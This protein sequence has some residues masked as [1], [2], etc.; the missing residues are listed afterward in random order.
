L[1]SPYIEGAPPFRGHRGTLS[2]CV[3]RSEAE[4]KRRIPQCRFPFCRGR[5]PWS[6]PLGGIGLRP[7]KATAKSPSEPIRL[8]LFVK[9]EFCTPVILRVAKRKRRI[10]QC[11]FPLWRGRVVV[12]PLGGIGLRSIKTTTKSPSEP[13]RVPLFSKG[14]FK[15]VILRVAK[16]KRR[17]PRCLLPFCRCGRGFCR[18]CEGLFVAPRQSRN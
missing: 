2:F 12:A 10:P 17:I 3:E 7:I 18:H 6:P 9:G 11:R 15:L 14:E 8:P 16:R 13:I 4:W 5:L 1:F